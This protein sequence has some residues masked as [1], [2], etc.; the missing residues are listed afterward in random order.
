MKKSLVS[1]LLLVLLF[2]ATVVLAQDSAPTVADLAEGITTIPVA[3]ATCARGT[4]YSFAARP[5]DPEKLMI[6]FQGG[7]ACWNDLTCRVGGTFDDVVEAGELDFYGGVFDFAN[8][9]NPLADYSMVIVMYCTGDVHIGDAVATFTGGEGAFDIDFKGVVNTRAVLDWTFANYPDVTNL[10]VAGT[11]AGAYGAIYHTPTILAQ[12]PDA[13]TLVFGDA[14]VGVTVAGWDGT[15]TWNMTANLPDAPEFS[16]INM[17]DFTTGLYAVNSALFPEVRFAEYTTAAD[18]VQVGFYAFQGAVP[19]GWAVGM[20]ASF[21]TLN[22]LDNFNSYLAWGSSHTILATP[23]L[24]SMQ[25]GGARFLDWFTGLVND[26]SVEN[27]A[28]SDCVAEE[29]YTP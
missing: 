10:I 20:Q 2:T 29:F 28:C 24:Y 9:E 14:G 26:D 3:G 16:D 19:S 11:S 17:D 15:E 5:G 25:V 8:A 13:Q 7:G 4:P 21:D 23:L 22:A 12:Y 27:I 18:E 1:F 6:Y